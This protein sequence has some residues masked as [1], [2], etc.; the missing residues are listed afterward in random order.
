[1]TGIGEGGDH[2]PGDS[3]RVA[4]PQGAGM[5]VHHDLDAH[6]AP[7]EGRPPQEFIVRCSKKDADK[8]VP[9]GQ[10]RKP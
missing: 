5:D 3:T 8:L 1:M 7:I 2:L 10:N 9:I 4:A 6:S